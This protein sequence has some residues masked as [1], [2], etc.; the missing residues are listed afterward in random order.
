MASILIID[1]DKFFCE[2]L[3]GF[4]GDLGH[5]VT[6]AFTIK[7]GLETASKSPFDIVYL[8]VGMPDG[9]GL[10][11]LPK[12]LKMQSAPEVIIMTGAGDPDGAELAIRCG[13]WDY[14]EKPSSM[15][16]II[17]PLLRAL[18]YREE[19]KAKKSALALNREGIIGQSPAIIDC[20]E[21]LSRAADGDMNILIQG[22]TG[23]GK[24]L[25]AWAI[26]QNSSRAENSF[27]V[28]DC[29]ALSESL[30]ES[31]LFGHEKGAFTGAAM[32]KDGL[33]SQ[34]DN[35][36]LFLDEI[37]E[38]PLNIQKAFL[39]V[40]QE[41]KFRPVGGKSERKSNFRLVAATN[42]DLDSMAS[43]GEFRSDLLFRI[44]SC[45]I[46]LPPLRERREDIRELVFHRIQRNCTRYGAP[47]KSFSPEFLQALSDYEWPG[48][49]RE[50]FNILDMAFANARHEPVL[51]PKHLPTDLRIRLIRKSEFKKS[52]GAGAPAGAPGELP[53]FQD[54]RKDSVMESERRYL[55]SLASL[56]G[57]DV[58]KASRISGL[59]RS[60]LYALFQKHNLKQ[61]GGNPDYQD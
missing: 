5:T 12:L 6:C 25:F 13:A 38:L 21:V 4:I 49:V 47:L 57:N 7:K 22:E 59:S 39:R 35:G 18:Q 45:I 20:F 23:T 58:S 8:D 30:V 53:K 55:Q 44:R 11:V 54:F 24:E 40:L 17:L 51:F 56:A 14:I 29:A 46:E 52:N 48:N 1:D 28:V 9:S 15:N 27:V 41:K 61:G 33:I 10:E 43:A 3:S 60:R 50:L 36:T 26:H 16:M 34:A 32:A 37:G 2:M 19:K 42:R 31:I